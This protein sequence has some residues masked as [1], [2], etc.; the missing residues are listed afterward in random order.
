MAPVAGSGLMV[1]AKLIQQC[2]VFGLM[3]GKVVSGCE[4]RPVS[5]GCSL[6]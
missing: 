5:P 2:V 3:R 6:H 4:I 1:T